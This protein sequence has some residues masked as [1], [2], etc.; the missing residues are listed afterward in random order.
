MTVSIKLS[1]TNDNVDIFYGF[2]KP[3]FCFITSHPPTLKNVCLFV[4]EQK[5]RE[6]KEN[7][8]EQLLSSRNHSHHAR[9]MIFL[10]IFRCT[11]IFCFLSSNNTN[12]FSKHSGY[13]CLD[14][15]EFC[16]NLCI[17]SR[18]SRKYSFMSSSS[19]L[20][21]PHAAVWHCVQTSS[22]NSDI[23]IGSSA[24]LFH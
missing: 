14:K 1:T 4:D 2:F 3:L 16:K 19:P 24:F 17:S 23:F 22:Y 11:T 15:L 5:Q 10:N 21:L 18:V 7:V 6:K 8:K 12:H 9:Y 13:F 20:P